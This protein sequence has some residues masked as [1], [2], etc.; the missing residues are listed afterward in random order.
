[1]AESVTLSEVYRA[2]ISVKFEG[3][4]AAA[5]AIRGMSDKVKGLTDRVKE[6]VLQLN[7]LDRTFKEMSGLTKLKPVIVP[8]EF[9]GR[10][11]E[12]LAEIR[13]GVRRLQPVSIPVAID[14]ETVRNFHRDARQLL[15]FDFGER[16]GITAGKKAIDQ[17]R[18][19]FTS[20]FSQL[21]EQT[22]H[23]LVQ[24][25][26]DIAGSF[27]TTSVRI[28]SVLSGMNQK[29][30][31]EWLEFANTGKEGAQKLYDDLVGRSIIPNMVRGVTRYM[32]E[33]TGIIDTTFKGLD[34]EM[35]GLA[36]EFD[37]VRAAGEHSS[38]GLTTRMDGLRLAFSKTGNT[39]QG[40]R[41]AIF[42]IGAPTN[43]LSR[44]MD[45]I[46]GDT[47]EL[48]RAQGRLEKGIVSITAATDNS[49]RAL[50]TQSVILQET[51]RLEGGRIR[52]LSELK[53]QITRVNRSFKNM[54]VQARKGADITD[55]LQRSSQEVKGLRQEYELLITRGIIKAGT[56][57]DK[58]F[59]AMI[60]DAQSMQARL[61]AVGARYQGLRNDVNQ[62][63]KASTEMAQSTGKVETT[64]R[65]A[66]EE[67]RSMKTEIRGA[68]SEASQL[69]TEILAG[70]A[71]GVIAGVTA[72]IVSNIG[73]ITN[74][75][76]EFAGELKAAVQL[77]TA[78]L[79]VAA[80]KAKIV[81]DVVTQVWRDNF[82]GSVEEVANVVSSVTRQMRRFGDVTD[83]ELIGVTENVFRVMDAFGSDYRET[84]DAASA[85]VKNFGVGWDE[86]FDF[87]TG[88]FQRGLDSSGDLLDS[89][90]EYAVQFSNSGGDLGSFFNILDSG[91]QSGVLGVDKAVDAWK[92]FRSR[93]LDG[94][95]TT[96][97]AL[98][99]VGIDAAEFTS[100]IA[101]GE[102]PIDR[103]FDIIIGR[104][105]ETG[106]QAVR[107]QAGV[108]LLGEQFQDLG[109]QAALS[110]T[111]TGVQMDDLAG[112]TGALDIQY[113]T[114]GHGIQSIWRS[115]QTTFAPAGAGM[116]NL[117][118]RY[119]P[120]VKSAIESL[121]PLVAA[122]SDAFT[123]LVT[124]I[125]DFV[126]RAT[127]GFDNLV[128]RLEWVVAIA[129]SIF[130]GDWQGAWNIFL[131]G[132]YNAVESA[133]VALDDLVTS[134]P[135]WG[136]NLI[137][138]IAN[139]IYEA[140]NSG[141][142]GA[143]GYVGSLIADFLA[144]GGS[145]PKQGALSQIDKW[146]R[147]VAGVYFDAMSSVDVSILSDTV[148][149]LS[150]VFRAVEGEGVEA[151]DGLRDSL[152][153][154]IVDMG[155]TGKV[156][157][158]L[159]NQFRQAMGV[160]SPF[161]E[162]ADAAV[163]ELKSRNDVIR[164]QETVRDIQDEILAAEAAGE[165]PPELE[166]KL[167]VAE[168][169]LLAAQEVHAEEKSRFAT[170]KKLTEMRKRAAKAEEQAAKK[171]E[172]AIKSQ[173]KAAVKS[174]SASAGARTSAAKKVAKTE[175][176]LIADTLAKAE[177]SY[178][179]E[180][181]LL[182]EK[183]RQGIISNA[184]YARARLRVEQKYFD[185]VTKNGE[186]ATDENIA[187]IKKYQAVV[188]SLSLKGKEATA[189]VPTVAA[190]GAEEFEV[191]DRTLGDIISTAKETATT[192]V[193]TLNTE[194]RDK[195]KESFTGLWE[196]MKTSIAEAFKKVRDWMTNL[197]PEYVFPLQVILGI[198]TGPL[199][200]KAFGLIDKIIPLIIRL[201]LSLGP[202]LKILKFVVGVTLWWAVA[203]LVVWEM[204]KNW[205]QVVATFKEVVGGVAGEIEGFVT[206]VKEMVTAFLESEKGRQ[207]IDIFLRAIS[208]FGLVATKVLG[209]FMLIT[210][211]ALKVVLINVVGRA[212]GFVNRLFDAFGGG[213]AIGER[214]AGV[215]HEIAVALYDFAELLD[216]VVGQLSVGNF[217]AA[218]EYLKQIPATIAGAF[219][220][221]ETTGFLSDFFS[222]I[223]DLIWNMLPP[224]FQQV[225]TEL[226][227]QFRSF[228]DQGRLGSEVLLLLRELW[229]FL[230]IALFQNKEAFT[231]IGT[232]L[233][234]VAGLIANVLL[235]ALQALLA[236]LPYI[237]GVLAGVVQAFRG[238]FGV[239]GGIIL[240]LRGLIGFIINIFVPG[241][242]DVEGLWVEG[243]TKLYEGMM[244]I[245]G[246]ILIAVG[247]F[248][249]GVIS[250]VLNFIGNFIANILDFAGDG[251]SAWA[252]TI[253]GWLDM[254]DTFW[255]DMLR[256]WSAGMADL[257]AFLT[258]MV[259]DI[260]QFFVDLAYDLV[261][262]SVITDMI[263]DIVSA[264]LGL[265]PDLLRILGDVALEVLDI[266]IGLGT[267]LIEGLL[268][269]IKGGAG[270][271]LE[272]VGS[273]FG[274]LLGGG[275]DTSGTGNAVIDM[276]NQVLTTLQ[277]FDTSARLIFDQVQRGWQVAVA[278]MAVTHKQF[279]AETLADLEKFFGLYLETEIEMGNSWTTMTTNMMETWL[280]ALGVNAK[281]LRDFRELAAAA[282]RD[283]I[284]QIE[285]VI[286]ALARMGKKAVAVAGKFD[287][288]M[289]AAE[290]AVRKLKEVIRDAGDAFA[291][292]EGK[293]QDIATDVEDLVEALEDLA[294]AIAD[295]GAI[296]SLPQ[297]Q[298]SSG[299]PSLLGGQR[300]LPSGVAGLTRGLGVSTVPTLPG[301]VSLT[302]QYVF[303][304][305][306]AVFPAV[307][308][309]R[310]ARN[311][312]TEIDR[313]TNLGELRG[314]I[315]G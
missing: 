58:Q 15:D 24:I 267:R 14:S 242:S 223:G 7:Q 310:D 138:E 100:K 113:N 13:R 85:L 232:I 249:M 146:G 209:L 70:L 191:G 39:A 309:G 77:T 188:A 244:N 5:Q 174:A 76:R 90:R 141:L 72:G 177:E 115:I 97:K 56:Q 226:V 35:K 203:G 280:K 155:K 127:G 205:D 49:I 112:K 29:A 136:Y 169:E 189:A 312:Q 195:V 292:L 130:S 163:D 42:G 143:L 180:I 303:M 298:Q 204:I 134:S 128:G 308:D 38:T 220:G 230:N 247:N 283:I 69:K 20:S 156:S 287:R 117:A 78:Q 288:A 254:W 94:S 11:G 246:G 96:S 259:S 159:L 4:S 301:G 200:W 253:R 19:L 25:I 202:L 276:V 160:E 181:A 295:L 74:S 8:W 80:D 3:A 48:G 9:E 50:K 95:E 162:M 228:F 235:S 297:Q 264:F 54:N 73:S 225:I 170:I 275:A 171:Q 120:M 137:I 215:F 67:F 260:V 153:A 268:E 248:L 273:L 10:P 294:E 51:H 282:M 157:K 53:G 148:S 81:G 129:T 132:I 45:K 289:S 315:V 279:I 59:K 224:G 103:A 269:G 93:I 92:E 64:A 192:F 173:G 208:K 302:R 219:A 255:V 104:L 278:L 314:T 37:N 186:Q 116:L 150:D 158:D 206:R 118:N 107:T 149:Q 16:G 305:G 151:F 236:V 65:G 313:L 179:A 182:D 238:V 52:D 57:A 216:V 83:E 43:M 17:F 257:I 101:A 44:A 178:T 147:E 270:T 263:L 265:G 71:T 217:E 197:P 86:A 258:D 145:P 131:E 140:A 221:G 281:E 30:A 33:M 227:D 2:T 124:T 261:G 89:V 218:W 31:A 102:I 135:D 119:I 199:V 28:I 47:T 284:S 250:L 185:T 234:I 111:T 105:R 194:I 300:L 210:K 307:T 166:A 175:Q 109:T 12:K 207:A 91:M 193:S 61:Q 32:G 68:A 106:N 286:L 277:Q 88:G 222:T 245:I 311:I 27:G 79:G 293:I 240:I 213:E 99:L 123:G 299:D 142:L 41:E 75:I 266:F 34:G 167:T 110:L 241:F 183:K 252:D 55:S 122:V 152:A 212:I 1:M 18:H 139:G 114:L 176:G 184:D 190:P 21:R 165:V 304:P 164:A 23:E 256:F 285:K 36:R 237:E 46:I 233:A 121:T 201:V 274:N 108:G 62:A 196:T 214:L 154:M 66:T 144:P 239:V 198:F 291:D 40:L 229:D 272:T 231:V 262:G 296:P 84:I 22:G 168:E 306:S 6:S 82:G 26:N 211:K 63:K 126:S 271:V 161:A 133:R 125:T 87:I 60:Q 251:E 98:Q 243:W 187:N 290:D 172:K